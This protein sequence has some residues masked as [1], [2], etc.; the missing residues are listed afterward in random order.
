MGDLRRV[1][2]R[3]QKAR[4]FNQFVIKLLQAFFLRAD[5]GNTFLQA[6]RG[7]RYPVNCLNAPG[8]RPTPLTQLGVKLGGGRFAPKFDVPQSGFMNGAQSRGQ[9]AHQTIR[10]LGLGQFEGME[11]DWNDANNRSFSYLEYNPV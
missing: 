9:G 11:A 7:L 6:A 8:E 4:Q 2:G 3:H 10:E 5:I 1:L